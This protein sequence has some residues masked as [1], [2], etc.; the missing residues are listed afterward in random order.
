MPISNECVCYC[1]RVYVLDSMYA[2]RDTKHFVVLHTVVIRALLKQPL[3]SW[4]I[5][6]HESHVSVTWNEFLQKAA[7]LSLKKRSFNTT[8]YNIQ[9]FVPDSFVCG[10]AYKPVRQHNVGFTECE[11]WSVV[12]KAE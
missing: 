7:D 11:E 6:C 5:R 1:V 10:P 2:V 12:A 9:G 8:F 3:H 4:Q